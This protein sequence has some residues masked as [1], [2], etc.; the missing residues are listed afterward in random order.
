[1]DETTR[2]LIVALRQA[3]QAERTGH[4]FYLNAAQTTIDPQG[5]E[6]FEQLAREEQDHFEFLSAH[7][8]ALVTTGQLAKGTRLQG[9][10]AVHTNSPL[11]SPALRERIKEAHFEMSALSIAVQLELNGINHYR[12]QAEKASNPEVKAFFE[13]LVAWETAH[14]EALLG[15]QES[16]QD[17]YWSESGFQPF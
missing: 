8:Q 5:K 9:H 10:S 6:A 14:Y 4:A 3:M 16:L 15:Q 12:E 1:M 7:Y 11:F 2:E 13:Q 17:D